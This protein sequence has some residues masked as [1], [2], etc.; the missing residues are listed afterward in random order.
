MAQISRQSEFNFQQGIGMHPAP[1]TMDTRHFS[2]GH[3]SVHLYPV[4][5]SYISTPPCTLMAWHFGKKMKYL[6]G[7]E[8]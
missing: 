5:R 8:S 4:P 6:E 3:E 1:Y 2:P 7:Q